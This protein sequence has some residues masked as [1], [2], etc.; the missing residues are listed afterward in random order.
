[1]PE[2]QLD[3]AELKAL[4]REHF[5]HPF[6]DHKAMH[7]SGTR[8]I[9][10]AR[11]V[12]VEDTD[13]H[14][15][16]D[17][18]AGL[19][20]V[21]IGYG[22]PELVQA[23]AEQ[24]QRLSYCPS[25]FNATHPSAILLADKLASMLPEGLNRVFF[26]S[27]G[28]EA[29]ETAVRALRRY[30]T[31]VGKPE[32]RIIIARENAYHGSTH[33]AA[34]LSGLEPMHKAGGDLPLPGIERINAP[35]QYRHGRD[36]DAESF[37]RMA[38]GWLE[39]K[40]LE[41][42]PENV[43]AFFAEPAQSA[44]GAICPPESYWPEVQR[45]CRKHDVLLV[46]DEVVMGFGRT[47]KWFGS[48]FYG[49]RPDI[50]QLGKGLTSG[51]LP[52]SACV[53]SDRVADVLV[54]EGG[55]WAHGYTYSGHPACCAVALEN[56]RLMEAEGIVE[57][58]GAEL[59]PRFEQKLAAFRDHPLVGEVRNVGLMAGFE[60]VAD[61]E[62]ATPYPQ[63]THIGDICA[64]EALSRGLAFRANGDTMSLMPPLT[65]SLPEMDEMF[66]I[67]RQALDATARRF[68]KM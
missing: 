65:M 1:M 43:A 13:G 61:K 6:T 57:R 8:V 38:A 18:L 63:D 32:K 20:C 56:I 68:G 28:S 11:G 33:I 67:A 62:T 54:D 46:V 45:I 52:L 19:G 15:T 25:F 48:D 36:M 26:Q 37:G 47:G 14:S 12:R 4:D 31:L 40:I 21:N 23:V 44:G 16:I 35:Y 7:N 58:A 53:L 60:L 51:Y 55:E 3:G 50:M 66:D 17:G 2:T 30:W 49:I 27:S 39:E 10:S 64:A 34:S 22:R 29:N 42:G 5:L 41:I 59:V 9:V 24:M